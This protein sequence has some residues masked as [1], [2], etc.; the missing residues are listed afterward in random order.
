LAPRVAAAHAHAARGP[1][2]MQGKIAAPPS[3]RAAPAPAS[4]GAVRAPPPSVREVRLRSSAR[5]PLPPPEPAQRCH[6]PTP[7]LADVQIRRGKLTV[8]DH[9]PKRDVVDA[10]EKGLHRGRCDKAILRQH[11]NR[12]RRRR[13]TLAPS[14]G[15]YRPT[16][17]RHG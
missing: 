7:M 17:F 11:T 4:D 2:A 5:A 10:A 8:T 15:T 12:R 16:S 1:M 13:F 6:V 3:P 9:A 14:L